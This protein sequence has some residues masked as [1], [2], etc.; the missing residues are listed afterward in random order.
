MLLAWPLL[1]AVD[2]TGAVRAIQLAQV[3]ALAARS[4]LAPPAFAAVGR[5]LG[6]GAGVRTGEALAWF[7]AARIEPAPSKAK[8]EKKA[9]EKAAVEAGASLDSLPQSEEAAPPR[10]RSCAGLPGKLRPQP[11]DEGPVPGYG[12]ANSVLV[13]QN[14]EFANIIKKYTIFALKYSKLM[15]INSKTCHKTC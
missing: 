2:P 14:D 8:E 10:P 11:G 5:L 4:A 15:I 13:I 1:G 9:V 3:A 12:G 6:T 7:F